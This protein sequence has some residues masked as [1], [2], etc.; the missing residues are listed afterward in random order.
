MEKT[1]TA[2]KRFV[3]IINEI[4]KRGIKPLLPR[5]YLDDPF[6]Q[7]NGIKYTPLMEGILH[8]YEP[9]KIIRFLEKRYGDAAIVQITKAENGEKIFL[10]KTGDIDSNQEIIDRDMALCGY[11]P[12]YVEKT[13]N[14][15]TIQYEPKHQNKVNE[16]VLEKKHIYHL[17]QS[18]KVPKIL[19]NG[20]EPKT[21][22]K[23]FKYPGRVYFFLSEPSYSKCLGLIGEFY[24]EELKKSGGSNAY[25]GSYTLLKIN[26]EQ[27]SGVDFSYDPNAEDCVYTYDNIPPEH[28][29]IVTVIE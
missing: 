22:N 28:I 25:E 14:E 23:K 11:F 8:T 27:L 15:R 21:N 19:K 9:E 10:I 24:R 16:K 13:G 29:E 17:T 3:R 26:T 5:H 18:Q 20:L 7:F 6:S 1:L 2:N 4:E 12:S